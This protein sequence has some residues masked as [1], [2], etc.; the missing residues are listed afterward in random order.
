[1][2]YYDKIAATILSTAI[3]RGAEKSTCP[4]EI[5]RMLFPDDWRRH[6]KDV[7]AVAIDLHKKG[8]VVITQKGTPV[9]VQN[10]KGP[11]RVRIN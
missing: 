3:H 10:I 2:Q 1:M 11:V 5:A 9:D 7:L 4:S 8:S 6:M